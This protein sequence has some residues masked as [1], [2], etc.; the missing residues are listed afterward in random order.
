MQICFALIIFSFFIYNIFIAQQSIKLFIPLLSFFLISFQKINGYINKDKYVLDYSGKLRLEEKYIEKDDDSLDSNIG[1][2][3]SNESYPE[4]PDGDRG[5][6]NFLINNIYYSRTARMEGIQGTV[7]VNFVVEKDGAISHV[8]TLR[9]PH[10]ILSKEAMRVVRAF[11]KWKP[12]E[13]DGKKVRAQF[14]M[15]VRFLLAG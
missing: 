3:Q 11:P 1:G 10:P 12:G 7:Y 4:F 14:N 8:K 13:Q 15:P 2:P 5:R 6:V 9:S